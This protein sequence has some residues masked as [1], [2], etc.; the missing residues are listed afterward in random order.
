MYPL[1]DAKSISANYFTL[2]TNRI[3]NDVSLMLLP[4]LNYEI[5]IYDDGFPKFRITFENIDADA[6]VFSLIEILISI[7]AR[8]LLRYKQISTRAIHKSHSIILFRGIQGIRVFHLR[9]YRA[10]RSKRKR[11]RNPNATRSEGGRN[12]KKEERRKGEEPL[13]CLARLFRLFDIGRVSPRQYRAN[14]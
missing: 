5:S 3:N 10:S 6:F 1:N 14:N 13:D 2:V 12:E 7:D 9:G 11:R 8:M 4:I